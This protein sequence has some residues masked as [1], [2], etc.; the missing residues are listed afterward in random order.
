MKIL[1]T[2]LFFLLTT[3]TSLSPEVVDRILAIVGTEVITESELDEKI[4]F[5]PE[6]IRSEEELE[7]L[8]SNILTRM[9]E[10]KLLLV[11][12]R[13]ESI[14]VEPKE[15][16]SALNESIEEIKNRF[17]S[18][19]ALKEELERQKITLEGLK[20]R[21]RSKIHDQLLVQ[22]WVQEK[23]QRK[24]TIS[25]LE[26]QRFF[27]ENP[28]SIP[29]LPELFTLSHI[30]IALLPSERTEKKVQ[31][32]LLKIHDELMGGETFGSLAK[33]YSE[34]PAS[35]KKGGDLGFFKKGDLVKELD[36]AISQIKVG[37]IAPIRSRYGY[38]LFEVLERK[39]E[40]VHARH[41]LLKV[42]PSPGDTL[43]AR[44]KIKNV[45]AKALGGQDFSELARQFSEDPE[46][47]GRGG[48]LGDY[49]LKEVN[50]LFKEAL[51]KLKVGEVSPV[52]ESP[53]GFHLI[54]LEK[55]QEAKTFTYDEIKERL[56][57]VLLQ[58]KME[59]VYEKKVAELMEEIYVE[60]RL[61]TG[62]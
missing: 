23:I 40:E 59:K 62:K 18:E 4:F 8:R 15:V 25:D 34:D 32:K 55:R 49:S 38:H 42:L 56:R 11:Q 21:H 3:S 35:S 28:D 45:R 19:E 39:G 12:A 1:C 52:I 60:N 9:I 46:S 26:V 5:Y 16:E 17:P 53:F 13:A 29:T 20:E 44:K 57:N 41:I 36:E 2:S 61:V 30:L 48:L 37:E 54:K 43:L 31:E 58:R 33:R 24:I 10:E 51:E 7:S 6:E 50:P 47:K 27:E 14:E 22:K